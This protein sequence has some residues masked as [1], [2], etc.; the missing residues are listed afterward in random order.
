MRALIKSR[1]TP[2]VTEYT[3]QDKKDLTVAEDVLTIM[4]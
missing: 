2:V 4:K 1:E 3:S